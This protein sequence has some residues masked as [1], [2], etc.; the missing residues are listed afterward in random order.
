MFSPI[1]P[2]RPLR[3]SSSVGPKPS[4]CRAAR[5][6]RPHRPDCSWRQLGCGVGQRQEAVVLG[7]KVGFAIHF[8]QCASGAADVARDDAFGGDAGSSLAGLVAQF[9]AQQFLGLV[10][11][12]FGFCQGLL[13]FHHGGVGLGAQFGDHACGNCSHLLLRCVQFSFN[14]IVKKRGYQSP[15]SQLAGARQA[16][17]PSS[18]ST[19]SSLPSATA[20]TTSFT[21]LARPSRMASAMPRAYSVTALA[22]SSLPGMT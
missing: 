9:D 6:V 5:P 3:T 20:L 17:A 11:V 19:N 15:F 13:A 14:S 12:A 4:C 10:H 8:Q 22:E 7:H 18:T 16:A 21:A 2:I 1:L